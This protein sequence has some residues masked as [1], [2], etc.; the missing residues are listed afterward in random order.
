MQWAPDGQGLYY[1][2]D[3]YDLPSTENGVWVYDRSTG[4]SSR[5]I[6]F[7]PDLA[8]PA[9]VEVA[10]TGGVGLIVY[11]RSVGVRASNPDD[12]VM[13]ADLSSGELT[14]IDPGA[15]T[16]G[17]D[18]VVRTATFSADGTEVLFTTYDQEVSRLWLR[19]L[20][21]G[22]AVEVAASIDWVPAIRS[23]GGGLDWASDGTVLAADGR[24]GGILLHVDPTTN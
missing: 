21:D 9:V 20:P 18:V 16:T 3:S 17:D 22:K 12:W 2:V 11:P 6:E 10:A 5:L 14:P 7:D 4:G 24:D 23:P 8:S 13:L 19:G 15:G 1:S